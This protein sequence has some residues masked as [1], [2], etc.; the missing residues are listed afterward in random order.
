MKHILFATFAV[1]LLAGIVCAQQVTDQDRRGF[2][3]FTPIKIDVDGDEQ[4]DTIK[5]RSYQVK[6]KKGSKAKRSNNESW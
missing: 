2:D 4:S 3:D 6:T 1:L 5:P